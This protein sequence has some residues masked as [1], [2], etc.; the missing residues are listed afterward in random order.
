MK[1]NLIKLLFLTL[2][3]CLGSALIGCS[4]TTPSSDCENLVEPLFL[5]YEEASKD[6]EL[7]L[8]RDGNSYTVIGLKYNMSYYQRDLRIPDY[9][10]DVPVT[11]IG[12]EAFKS[13]STSYAF[14]LPDTLVSLGQNS[15]PMKT[16][17]MVT[18]DG[19]KYLGSINN[20][21]LVANKC[22]ESVSVINIK[23]RCKIL[24]RSLQNGYDCITEIYLPS[25]VQTVFTDTLNFSSLAKIVVDSENQY[26]STKDGVLYDKDGTTLKCFPQSMPLSE[27]TVPLG[28]EKIDDY[29]FNHNKFLKKLMLSDTVKEIGRSFNKMENLTNIY[30][31]NSFVIFDLYAFSGTE[32]L[33][34][35]VKDYGFY[36]GSLDNPYLFLY[37]FS[38]DSLDDFTIADSCK[39]V[40]DYAFSNCTIKEL[41]IPKSVIFF[42][43]NAFQ[44]AKIEKVIYEG[45]ALD[46]CNIDFFAQIHYVEFY[47]EENYPSYSNPLCAGADLYI[48]GELLTEMVFPE[49][50]SE[51]KGGIFHGYSKLTKVVLPQTVTKIGLASFGKCANLKDITLPDSITHIGKWAFYG[52]S[53]IEEIYVSNVEILG[54]RAF[55]HCSS[56][57]SITMGNKVTSIEEK[58]FYCCSSLTEI[59]F[60]ENLET[61]KKQAFEYCNSLE[62]ITLPQSVKKIG[63][64][65]FANC[66]NLKTV[67]LGKNINSLEYR[68]FNNCE[69]LTKINYDGTMESWKSVC[70]DYS[71]CYKHSQTIEIECSDGTIIKEPVT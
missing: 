15:L 13:V 22:V 67:N 40:G 42:G 37:R 18:V 49:G 63:E 19:V 43:D 35:N 57:K 7:E 11:A 25:T 71:I 20:P 46:W 14:Y 50:T 6:F 64:N 12:Y 61:V 34:F 38:L 31:P 29:A 44:D 8:N 16:S 47:L 33:E 53:S 69:L 5:S 23:E 17:N 26:F 3:I 45:S 56:L 30:L 48:N 59:V 32:K 4:I 62:T 24:D 41:T 2:L 55:A 60:S 52:C 58:T 66:A 51:I 27:F 28:V 39:Y 68:I 70:G 65:A 9:V 36:L 21:Y 54:E 1:T 10:D